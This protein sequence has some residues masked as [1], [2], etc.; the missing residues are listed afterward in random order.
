VSG[1]L[2]SV[3]V[4]T[5]LRR[6]FDYILPTEAG[7]DLAPGTRV[8]VA[9]GKRKLVG[10]AIGTRAA[11]RDDA[12]DYRAIDEVLDEQP[13]FS[14]ELL[15]LCGFAADYYQ[16]PIGDVFATALPGPL[17][18]GRPA[19]I[20][21]PKAV[22]DAPTP[23]VPPTP[24]PAQDAAL[25]ALAAQP[26]G[27]APTLL[28]GVTGSGK[29][30]IY[31]QRIAGLIADGGQAL[32]LVPEIGLTPQLLERFQ[33]R[34]GARVAAFHSGMTEAQRTQ[35]WLR[36]RSG[37]AG[38]II[39]TRSAIFVP[40]ARLGLI[41]VDEE[42]DTSYKQQDGL[43]YS[44]RDLA[45]WRA[46]QLDIP[47]ILGS[48]TPSLE[49]LHQA[50][51]GRYQHLQLPRR[52]GDDTPPPIRL[53]D[54]RTRPLQGGLSPP[55]LDAVGRHVEAGGQALLFLNRRGYAPALLCEACAWTAQCK[56]CDARLSLHRY[57]ER[58]LCHHCGARSAPPK[59][60]P[61]CGGAEL[62]ALGQGTERV[63]QALRERFPKARIERMDSD[64]L[65]KAGELQRLL[66]DI[67]DGSVQI[68][69]GTQVVAKGHDFERLSLVGIV[70]AD[71]ALFGT[72]FR[73]L[74]RVGQVITQVAGRA[75]RSAEST[76][77]AEVILQTR[78]PSHPM[79]QLLLAKGYRGLADAL[80]V[81]RRDLKMP[82]FAHLALLRAESV[83]A[84]AAMAFLAEA[85]RLFGAPGGVR[86]GEPVPA[87]MERRA[88]RYRAQLLLQSAQRP[89]LLE[90]LKNTIPQIEALR[91]A[92][93][94]RWS[95]DV[96]PADLF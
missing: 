26:R 20:K 40:F 74:E 33:H 11:T 76:A 61:D 81:E 32:V 71:Q 94:A 4:P 15:A 77:R 47:V 6:T 56:R 69:I 38:V 82:P 5:P 23:A 7:S 10:I 62:H 52:P 59:V 50:Q 31:L 16:H 73:A 19:V 63:E 3:A 66:A 78:E 27:F 46:R 41:V 34:L 79:W 51:R 25:A 45:I 2:L 87:P 55:L 68:L 67:R 49:S 93:K 1:R 13:L 95:I 12:R 84:E 53:L 29:T 21:P 96:D 39:G 54:V 83:H 88:G 35:S 80:L 37:E 18:R 70:S 30:E 58:L 36:A 8:R 86:V 24:T 72:D 17:R 91:S 90:L 85:R 75:G 22:S 89:A 92:R 60:C 14:A 28:E 44:A 48:A 43:R 64:R 57:G 42:H 65:A 9:F